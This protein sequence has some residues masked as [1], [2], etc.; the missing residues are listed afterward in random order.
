MLFRSILQS[1]AGLAGNTE[2]TDDISSMISMT[3]QLLTLLGSHKDSFSSSMT[4]AR[5]I[6]DVIGDISNIGED[7]ISDIDDLDITLD[8]YYPEAISTLKDA[9]ALTDAAA[10]GLDSL[11]LFLGSLEDQ[12]KAVGEPLNSGTRKTLNG[13]ADILEHANSGL[14]QTETVRQAKDTIK[15]TIEDVYK[16]QLQTACILLQLLSQF[17]FRLL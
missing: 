6:A 8:Y 10:K 3:E 2:V 17:F 14:A 13:L 7:I 5:D 12:I 16:R 11:N 9:G 4:D 1:T 15:D